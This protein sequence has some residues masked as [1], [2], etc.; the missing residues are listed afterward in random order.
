M[1]SHQPQML[2]NLC[3]DADGAMRGQVDSL[4]LGRARYLSQQDQHLLHLA[5][6]GR[7]SYRQIAALVLSNP[8]SVCRRVN[9]LTRRLSHP[10]VA[11]LADSPI[12]LCDEYQKVGLRRF[13]WGQSLRNIAR[14]MEIGESQ[15]RAIVNFLPRW[16]KSAADLK[17]GKA[18]VRETCSAGV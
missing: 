16:F 11:M 9:K 14:E 4:I 8:G 12:G 18:D 3:T 7:N 17:K 1:S 10:F 15:V 6:T 5:L 2:L 13:L